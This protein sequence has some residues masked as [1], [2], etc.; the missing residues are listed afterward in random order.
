MS[1][2]VELVL[3][4]NRGPATFE[5][6]KDGGF[7]PRRGGGGL[8]TALTGLVH[9]RDALWIASTLSDEDAEAAAQH[10]GGSFECEL[11]DVTYRIRLVESDADAYE[12]FYNVVANPMLWF[13]QHYL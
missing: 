1:G 12:R 4:S 3:V 8:V 11:E 2:D 5:R 10:G 7:E 6:T 9:H 13:I